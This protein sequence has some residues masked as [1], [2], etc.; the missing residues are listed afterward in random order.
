MKAGCP[1]ICGTTLAQHRILGPPNPKRGDGSPWLC[2]PT[3]V[4][5]SS[6]RISQNI[7]IM[8]IL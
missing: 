1:W 2:E 7:R 6:Q 4:K 3:P 8:R 5:I